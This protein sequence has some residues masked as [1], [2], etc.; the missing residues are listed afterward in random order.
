MRAFSL[1]KQK[2]EPSTKQVLRFK[3]EEEYDAFLAEQVRKA[4]KEVIITM[5]GP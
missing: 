1:K 2:P 3:S 4:K 5:G